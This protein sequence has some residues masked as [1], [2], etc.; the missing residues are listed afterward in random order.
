MPPR[1]TKEDTEKALTPYDRNSQVNQA[2]TSTSR[3]STTTNQPSTSNT[4]KRTI[5][6]EQASPLETKVPPPPFEL[7]LNCIVGEDTS[8]ITVTVL[9]CE[10]F[11]ALKKKIKIE[12]E[13]RL[14]HF[15][16]DELILELIPD[17]GVTKKGL[18]KLTE[19]SL[20]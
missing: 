18:D 6:V 20:E 5:P 10:N 11:N 2:S 14:D 7:E 12:K 15:A 9:S 16:A 17:G 3:G 13:P 4:K 19:S 8:A 1:R